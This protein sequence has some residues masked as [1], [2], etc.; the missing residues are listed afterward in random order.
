MSTML[1]SG[2]KIHA[3]LLNGL[4]TA[5]GLKVDGL[6]LFI[7]QGALAVAVAVAVGVACVRETCLYQK[8]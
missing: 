3:R 6:R 2:R 8:I 4:W 1:R 7:Y 5:G